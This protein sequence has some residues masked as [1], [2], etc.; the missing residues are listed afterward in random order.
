MLSTF[1]FASHRRQLLRGDVL[2]DR[3]HGLCHLVRLFL[4]DLCLCRVRCERIDASVEKQHHHC[5][6]DDDY[7]S[8]S[9]RDDA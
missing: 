8:P 9:A 6:R 2:H 3:V 7:N 4:R 5:V 1:L